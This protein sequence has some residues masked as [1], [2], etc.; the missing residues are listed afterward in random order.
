MSISSEIIRTRVG[1]R[2]DDD[3]EERSIKDDVY[4]PLSFVHPLIFLHDQWSRASASGISVSGNV[5]SSHQ[6]PVLGKGLSFTVRAG[7]FAIQGV[8]PS[9]SL[10]AM[11][12]PNIRYTP[13]SVK[14]KAEADRARSI[15]NEVHIL[16]HG[17][18]RMHGN[19]VQLLALVW[20]EA[21][22]DEDSLVLMMLM[23]PAKLGTLADLQSQEKGL[24]YNLKMGLC[25]DISQGLQALH[26][27]GVVHGDVKS[28][29]VLIFIA[30]DDRMIAK[31]SDFGTA[32][33][34]DFTPDGT[35]EDDPEYY[36]TA[37]TK[38]WMAP[39][40]S[41]PVKR[42]KLHLTDIYSF[43]LLAW[44]VLIDGAN[45]FDEFDMPREAEARLARI[46]AIKKEFSASHAGMAI[47]KI[48]NSSGTALPPLARFSL[49][50]LFL[51]TIQ[52]EPE[53]RSLS[54]ALNHG[55]H[56]D[57]YVAVVS[58]PH[59]QANIRVRNVPNIDRY[60]LSPI[61]FDTLKTS[62]VSSTLACVEN[63]R[64]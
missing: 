48:E 25:N 46:E 31:V 2:N 52:C 30:N 19:I 10:V 36:L 61:Q 22:S 8:E 44:R 34:I 17:P 39:E 32:V 60:R 28:E 27:C 13:S 11:K 9:P 21:T 56:H 45:P 55:E 47:A 20:T 14:T 64:S 1:L 29:N 16:T 50:W 4:S 18:L 49:M 57:M 43:G 7:T 54:A 58:S 12:V 42:S 51:R 15:L 37:G 40:A 35:L 41:G 5:K 62:A 59:S 63:F 23:E 3:T 6:L 53:E 26:I 38:L 24:S 33:V